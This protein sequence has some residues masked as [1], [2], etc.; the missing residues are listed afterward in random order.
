MFILIMDHFADYIDVW[1][2]YAHLQGWQG[3]HH[4]TV[5]IAVLMIKLVY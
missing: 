2:Y 3:S 4:C 1:E 5:F